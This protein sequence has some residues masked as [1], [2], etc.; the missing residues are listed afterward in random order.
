MRPWVFF[1]ASMMCLVLCVT[2]ELF[3]LVAAAVAGLA[4]HARDTLARWAAA[5][6]RDGRGLLVRMEPQRCPTATPNR[7]TGL[8]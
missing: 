7:P 5:V 3:W 4:G 8:S 6:E 1:A 2:L